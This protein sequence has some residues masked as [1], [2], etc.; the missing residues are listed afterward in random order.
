VS[1]TIIEEK[2][3]ITT[4]DDTFSGTFA[5]IRVRESNAKFNW[6]FI[7]PY[8]GTRILLSDTVST[9]YIPFHTSYT[10]AYDSVGN[11]YTSEVDGA[12]RVRSWWLTYTPE[13]RTII[14]RLTA[15]ENKTNS[16]HNPSFSPTL[17]YKPFWSHDYAF[18]CDIIDGDDN[19]HVITKYCSWH[20]KTI[21]SN[22]DGIADDMIDPKA[23][24]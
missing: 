10:H 12:D 5:R 16:G 19:S 9:K 8:N 2:T 21:H 18:E 24:P 17:Q 20:A 15:S 1:I 23:K 4:A 7:N 22:N 13:N 11:Y 3:N 6:Y 14:G